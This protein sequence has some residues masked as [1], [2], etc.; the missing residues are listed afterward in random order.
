MSK[1]RSRSV[2][3]AL[4][5]AEDLTVQ[6]KDQLEFDNSATMNVRQKLLN[7]YREIILEDLDFAVER[8]VDIELWNH[9]FRQ[10]ISAKQQK[11]KDRKNPKRSELQA[12]LTSF[13]ESANG[14]YIVLLH[15]VCLKFR[16]SDVPGFVESEKLGMFC[17][18][19]QVADSREAK[20]V[21]NKA[22]CQYFVQDSLIH[23]GDIARYRSLVEQ[24]R[25]YYDNAIVLGPLNGKP[26][27]QLAIILQMK[28]DEN[29]LE[30]FFYLIRSIS[31]KHAFSGGVANLT[32]T[33][34]KWSQNENHENLFSEVGET[35]AEYERVFCYFNSLVFFLQ[36]Y[37]L[38][39]EARD[40]LVATF[41]SILEQNIDSI[42][43]KDLV[44]MIFVL[45]FSV[46]SILFSGENVVEKFSS[47]SIMTELTELSTIERDFLGLT[48][49]VS[50]AVFG[51]LLKILAE[52][53]EPGVLFIS[54][55]LPGLKVV[56]DWLSQASFLLDFVE[57][58]RRQFIWPLLVK[59]VNALTRGADEDNFGITDTSNTKPLCEDFLIQGFVPLRE[60]LGRLS[61]PCNVKEVL[62]G[63]SATAARIKRISLNVEKLCEIKPKLI[64]AAIVNGRVCFDTLVTAKGDNEENNC[65]Q[66]FFGPGRV[67]RT[68]HQSGNTKSQKQ[69]K[70]SQLGQMD[71]VCLATKTTSNHEPS[72]PAF[73]ESAKVNETRG[74]AKPKVAAT[75]AVDNKNRSNNASKNVTF[76]KEPPKTIDRS[77][78]PHKASA[79][80]SSVN[81]FPVLGATANHNQRP[82]FNRQ[83][84]GFL[85]PNNVANIHPPMGPTPRFNS[86][87]MAMSFPGVQMN[88]N[89]SQSLS[90]NLSQ[91]QVS[92]MENNQKV[93]PTSP[94]V[95]RRYSQQKRE[96]MTNNFFP[97]SNPGMIG[98]SSSAGNGEKAQQDLLFP[99]NTLQPGL[100]PPFPPPPLPMDAM[101][102]NVSASNIATNNKQRDSD[103][104]ANFL[105]ANIQSKSDG[106]RDIN[107]VGISNQTSFLQPM[108]NP[109]VNASF[110]NVR[111]PMDQEFANSVKPYNLTLR[112]PVPATG[113][114]ALGPNVN[115]A[116]H[117]AVFT[118][119]EKNQQYVDSTSGE[120]NSTS[121]RNGF[122][123]GNSDSH[124]PPGF[125]SF[126]PAFLNNQQSP[127]RQ[128]Q[129]TPERFPGT[130]VFP[131]RFSNPNF[132]RQ[133]SLNMDNTT[134]MKANFQ[135]TA[136]NNVP[137]MAPNTTF[138]LQ[139]Q[140]SN[141]TSLPSF[142]PIWSNSPVFARLNSNN[143]SNNKPTAPPDL[144]SLDTSKPMNPV[145][146]GRMPGPLQMGNAR[147]Q[148]NSN[149]V[150]SLF[151]SASMQSSMNAGPFQRQNSEGD[152]NNLLAGLFGNMSAFE[153]GNANVNTNRS[154]FDEQLL[155]V[156][157][158]PQDSLLGHQGG[159]MSSR[160]DSNG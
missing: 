69:I 151:E 98:N 27:N 68:A 128:K 20:K 19:C 28:N 56:L 2:T 23:L 141:P 83:Q 40:Y 116:N 140:I 73:L 90:Q 81:E 114:T 41:R 50:M 145:G 157:L 108:N 10:F 51:C 7:A 38:A 91:N 46:R 95:P 14:F 80:V 67:K 92:V 142:D 16:I 59:V 159:F 113:M 84:P 4:Q 94:P 110:Q 160:F 72:K 12:N 106:P 156:Q 102:G 93:D 29:Q 15:E 76:G 150:Q 53:D 57:F 117:A 130:D 3:E 112:N 22:S 42:S 127:V 129:H 64:E 107:N 86:P 49:D 70:N 111:K 133:T 43:W 87:R 21:P 138:P 17:S 30:T 5:D 144:M 26:Y 148:Q 48:T 109:M 11:S 78:S 134:M 18:D 55:I 122:P 147:Q 8:K 146:P 137:S 66:R 100:F 88:A 24:A 75:E 96:P 47:K 132:S 77:P 131:P 79:D 52:V 32:T 58:E 34:T 115:F 9:C 123:Q 71:K 126:F 39:T 31:V 118:N 135:N 104:F 13:L 89:L 119:T 6:L 35:W 97:L 125:D 37:D 62:K 45:I 124:V 155:P 139:R 65:R 60:T 143:N 153:R 103:P 61:L 36:D 120:Q 99:S 121:I 101:N 33:L 105:P 154:N 85:A 136:P 74:H 82:S 25:D 44:R 152:G 63:K 149:I 1:R 54:P 158:R